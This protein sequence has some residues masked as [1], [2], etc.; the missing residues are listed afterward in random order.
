VESP[1]EL[2][3]NFQADS[4]DR[5]PRHCAGCLG[6]AAQRSP[7]RTRHTTSQTAGP[8]RHSRH[9]LLEIGLKP[10]PAQKPLQ[11]KS[12]RRAPSAWRGQQRQPSN[13][14]RQPSRPANSEVGQQI[15]RASPNQHSRPQLQRTPPQG[16]KPALPTSLP[17][18][19][20]PTQIEF[21]QPRSHP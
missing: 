3:P 14:P 2:K 19:R 7:Q 11:S 17:Q 8:Q 18:R 15:Q 21:R 20:A 9:P 12:I 5:T 16:T 4:P 1:S 10:P 6:V 13:S